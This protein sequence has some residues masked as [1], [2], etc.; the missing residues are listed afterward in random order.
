MQAESKN[1]RGITM[2]RRNKNNEFFTGLSIQME[3]V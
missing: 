2:Q 3:R 1:I